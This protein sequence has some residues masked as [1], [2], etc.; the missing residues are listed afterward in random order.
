MQ[1]PGMMMPPGAF[2]RP[3]P[4]P[5]PSRASHK[6]AV[7]EDDRPNILDMSYEEYLESFEKMKKSV[8][9][10]ESPQDQGAS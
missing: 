4:P 1:Q 5:P 3:P 9:L 7:Q 6:D 8:V 2:V 10:S